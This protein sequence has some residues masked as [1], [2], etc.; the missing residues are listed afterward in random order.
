MN[1][2]Y[3]PSG[4]FN[5]IRLTAAIAAMLG[6]AV[7]LG[8]VLGLIT[9]DGWYLIVIVP[10]VALVPFSFA[11]F[12]LSRWS[13]LR[14][15][16]LGY[17]LGAILAVTMY[18]VQF[19]AMLVYQAG[20]WAALR[21]DVLPEYLVHN[22]NTQ[23]ISEHFQQGKPQPWYNW[24][25]FWVE[26]TICAGAGGIGC[27]VAA[28]KPYC[29]QCGHWLGATTTTLRGGCAKALVAA[30]NSGSLESLPLL[31]PI[32]AERPERYCELSV[33]G[34]AHGREIEE[35]TIYVSVSEIVRDERRKL[36]TRLVDQLQITPD[37]LAI[38]YERC[39]SLQV[40][41]CEV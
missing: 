1:S 11:G 24:I 22:V 40:E 33:A 18:V 27:Y 17:V 37:D 13:H 5:P 32:F 31:E 23:I 2:H 15:P 30:L 41:P 38:L 34:C 39:P 16:P 8:S 28:K 35:A 3:Q 19:H 9:F 25:V 26:L 20:P 10:A 12:H 36:A 21:L 29:E 14:N 6:V 7:A 4:L